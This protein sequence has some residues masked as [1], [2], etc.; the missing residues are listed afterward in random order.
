MSNERKLALSPGFVN[1]PDPLRNRRNLEPAY[2]QTSIG[3]KRHG[4]RLRSLGVRLLRRILLTVAITALLIFAGIQWIAPAALSFYA[5]RKAPPVVRVVPANL[6]DQSISDSP[7][8]KLSYFGYEFE[9]PWDDLDESHTE[10]YPKDKPEKNGVDLR[11]RSGLRLHVVAL[12]PRELVNGLSQETG[13]LPQALEREFGRDTMDSD[14]NF[15][16]VLYEF[17]PDKM[18]HLVFK[19]GPV[20]RDEFLLILKSIVPAKGADSGIF[21]IRNRGYQGFQQGSC[22]VRKDRI[23]V[24]LYS[25]EGGVEMN[26]FQK[27]YRDFGGITQPEINRIIQSLHKACACTTAASPVAKG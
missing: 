20:N 14:Y 9:V 25:D 11:F 10:F 8:M 4:N 13:V 5:V 21:Y 16:K 27:D 22:Q 19:Q 18:N 26:L 17:T 1:D 12:P 15:V 24:D 6:R 2:P 3:F 7:G 23:T